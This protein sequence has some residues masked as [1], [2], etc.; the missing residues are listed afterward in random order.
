MKRRT[1]LA[2]PAYGQLPEDLLL[3]AVSVIEETL[4]GGGHDDCARNGFEEFGYGGPVSS[5]ARV[6]RMPMPAGGRGMVTTTLPN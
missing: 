2:G 5:C 3:P 6:N 1:L 4:P